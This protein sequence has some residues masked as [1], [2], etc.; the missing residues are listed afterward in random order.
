MQQELYRME[1]VPVCQNRVYATAAVARACLLGDLVLAQDAATGLVANRAYDPARLAYDADYQN[2][3][4]CS[5]TFRGHLA[6]VQAILARH[7]TGRR[8]V[9]VGC[10]KGVF[11]EQLRGACYDVTGFDPTYEG[12]SPHIR[13]EFFRPGIGFR[14]DGIVLRHVLEHVP[15]PVAFL[16]SLIYIEV[17][18]LD[19]ILTRRT[20]FDIFYEHV[21]YFRASDFHRLFGR[22][23]EADHLFHGQYLYAVADLASLRTPI[24]GPSDI[25]AWPADFL[26]SLHACVARQ[27]GGRPEARAVWGAAAKGATF[28][29]LLHRAGIDFA[30]VCDINPAKH[31]RYLAGSGYRVSPPAELLRTLPDGAEI[32][33][34]NANYFDEI[35]RQGGARFRYR[36]V[37]HEPEI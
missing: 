10:G 27:S 31:G 4:A 32:S 25:V 33:V 6:E 11:L 17:P 14:A 23:R 29:H 22:L 9:E 1:S 5:S 12:D 26:A 37:D 36:M 24:A 13:R 2:E 8:L 19:W 16:A 3:Q 21:N 18:C 20:W 35:V 30:G 28:L 7:L 34:M 15:D